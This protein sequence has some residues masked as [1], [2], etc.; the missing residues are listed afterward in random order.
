MTPK[1]PGKA[2]PASRQTARGLTL[3]T[4]RRRG[5]FTL[6]VRTPRGVLDVERS[7][8]ALRLRAPR[9]VHEIIEGK[10]LPALR[11][12]L[13]AADGSKRAV[14]LREDRVPFGPCVTRP[15]KI[16]MMGFN[17]RRHC[18]EAKAPIPAQPVFF[19]KFNNALLGHGGTIP[20]PVK[21]ASQFD[22]EA[23]LVVVVGRTARDVSPADA[24]SHVFG[25]CSGN[26]FS[27]RDLQFKTSQ[28]MLG[29]CCDG[30]APIG[31]WLVGAELVADPQSLAI[32]CSVNGELRQSSSTSD[33]IFSC[34]DLVSYAS[35]HMT[36]KPGDVIFTGTPE[37]VILGRPEPERVWLKPGDRISTAVGSLGEL[38]FTLA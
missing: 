3:C 20:L 2:A 26:D 5:G 7:A 24:L 36:L 25:Y 18:L 32:E 4:I 14:F 35:R 38:R 21:V 11:R 13:A 1:A 27:A 17:Y 33:M 37:G 22:Y 9:D 6:G 29:K 10:D 23:E 31:P 19:N 15:E 8:R 30:F 34:A 12:L 28:F 16:V